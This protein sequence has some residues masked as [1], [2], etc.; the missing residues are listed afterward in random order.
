MEL[1]Q[2]EVAGAAVLVIVGRVTIDDAPVLAERLTLALSQQAHRL[3]LDLSRVE[4]MGSAGLGALITATKHARANGGDVVFAAPSAVV[5]T[6]LHV[7]GLLDFVRH[8][9]ATALAVVLL[10]A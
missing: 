10:P 1:Y 9:N 3:V 4:F 6:L 2:Q 8:A 7:S 5:Q